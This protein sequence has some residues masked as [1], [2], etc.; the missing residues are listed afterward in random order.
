MNKKWCEHIKFN[1]G[2]WRLD[3]KD[4]VIGLPIPDH[5]LECPIC[6]TYKPNIPNPNKTTLK[7][8]IPPDL[9]K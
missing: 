6:N 8:Y 2:K 9:R 4:I 7:Q 1:D 5:I 3:I